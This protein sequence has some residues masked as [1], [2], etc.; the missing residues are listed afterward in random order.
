[1]DTQR[2]LVGTL[3]SVGKK[4]CPSCHIP[5]HGSPIPKKELTFSYPEP[6]QKEKHLLSQPKGVPAPKKVQPVC[7]FDAEDPTHINVPDEVGDTF[8]TIVDSYINASSTNN[9]GFDMSWPC[10]VC[11]KARHTF[12]YCPV[13]Q[14]VNFLCR[15]YIQFKLFLKKQS[16]ATATINYVQ[17][18]DNSDFSHVNPSCGAITPAE[19]FHQGQE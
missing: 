15:H 10:A 18:A 12:N 13:L 11:N 7:K 8:D 19:D 6:W 9:T 2:N 4:I 17:L 16:T 14:N 1:M 5:H 3:E